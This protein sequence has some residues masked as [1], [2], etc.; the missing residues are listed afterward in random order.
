MKIDQFY[1][2]QINEGLLTENEEM[3]KK[4]EELL[5]EYQRK[6]FELKCNTAKKS[7]R[8]WL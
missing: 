7:N 8:K 1:L 2:S 3:V 6:E 4:Y 5:L